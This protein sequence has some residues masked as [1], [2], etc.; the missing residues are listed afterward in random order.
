MSIVFDMQAFQSVNRT[1]G[2]GRFNAAFLQ[3]LVAQ[4]PDGQFEV[5]FNGTH[6]STPSITDLFRPQ[7]Y[8]RTI[9]YLPG[10]DLN[11]ANTEIFY[12]E[13]KPNKGDIFHIL[14]PM[15][16][17]SHSVI[18][19][20]NSD[21]LV[22]S[23]I[24]DFIPFLF[25]EQYLQSKQELEHYLERLELLGKS[26][27]FF[28]ISEQTKADAIEILHV[29]T[30]KV[31]NIGIA[32]SE[33]FYN[34]QET[35]K[36]NS[37]E[38]LR[39]SGVPSKFI[40]SIS[41]LDPRKNL[42][43]LIEAY[44]QLPALIRDEYFLLLVSNTP[45]KLLAANS[46]LGRLLE[47]EEASNIRILY[48]ISDSLLNALYNN[49]SL[50]IMASL[51]EGGG[52]PIIEAQRCGA[53]VVASNSSSLPEFLGN[54]Q[55]LFTPHDVNSISTKIEEVLMDK[56]LAQSLATEGL[57]YSKQFTWKSITNKIINAYKHLM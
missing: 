12:N 10:N 14:S 38:D 19:R 56:I 44:C 13:V 2:I 15:E 16:P 11:K 32:P 57:S 7:N 9:S 36:A 20:P 53:P 54:K 35:E 52:L 45:V 6:G 37:K 47:K 28:A 41:N 24:Y 31:L 30:D 29:P 25:Q 48:S 4:W 26:D 33:I 43:R 51:Y 5:I 42:V 49:C 46:E 39:R 17:Q 34:Y 23:T 27:Y 55:G 50:F 3:E 18:H 1:G 40:L 22:V 8:I 21:C